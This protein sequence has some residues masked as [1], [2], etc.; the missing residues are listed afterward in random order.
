MAEDNDADD[1]D[2]FRNHTKWA[3]LVDVIQGGW[4]ITQVTPNTEVGE[5]E[6]DL[7]NDHHNYK[8]GSFFD[9]ETEKFIE[10]LVELGADSIEMRLKITA[11]LSGVCRSFME[12]KEKLR[13]WQAEESTKT[14]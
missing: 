1:F 13:N 11:V 14:E 5:Y 2:D 9:E 7:C 10:A 6:L 4:L 8:I 3:I 12:A